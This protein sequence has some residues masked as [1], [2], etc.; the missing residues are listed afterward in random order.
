MSGE[1]ASGY[2]K[3]D[4]NIKQILFWTI[5]M[6]LAIILSLVLLN[7][8]FLSVKEEMIYEEVLKPESL[9]LRDVR[10]KEDLLLNSY[11][12][13]DSTTQVYRIPIDRAMELVAQEAYRE[14]RN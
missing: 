12:L 5:A 8:Y 1:H 9:T 6:V 3:K 10:A 4:V 7:E 14:S 13:I 2:E 11:E